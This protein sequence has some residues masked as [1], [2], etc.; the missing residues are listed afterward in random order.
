[1]FVMVTIRLCLLVILIKCLKGH[2]SRGTL[3]TV[4]GVL[5]VVCYS[6]LYFVWSVH[7]VSNVHFVYVAL[8]IAKLCSM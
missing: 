6:M 5:F 4:Q 8:C 1:M 2:K 3:C 7:H